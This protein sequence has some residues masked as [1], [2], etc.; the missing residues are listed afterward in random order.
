SVT[1]E[2]ILVQLPSFIAPIIGLLLAFR[3]I[4]PLSAAYQRFVLRVSAEQMLL[5]GVLLLGFLMLAC[6]MQ[7][8][9]GWAMFCI[10]CALV[11]ALGGAIT[12]EHAAWAESNPNQSLDKVASF[13]NRFRLIRQKLNNGTAMVVCSAGAIIGAVFG[14]FCHG[15]QSE[16]SL[17]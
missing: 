10:G 4:H 8:V 5:A 1:A 3:M 9:P 7:S 16:G 15:Q 17:F 13:Q 2:N 6:V 11:G 14:H 12:F